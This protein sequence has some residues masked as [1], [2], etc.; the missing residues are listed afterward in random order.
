MGL[1][2]ALF[3]LAFVTYIVSLNISKQGVV[4]KVSSIS[5]TRMLSPHHH[6][7][8]HLSAFDLPRNIQISPSIIILKTI[9]FKHPSATPL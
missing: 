9:A 8:N 6:Q 4:Q 1:K 7:D 3:R 2:I 5:P